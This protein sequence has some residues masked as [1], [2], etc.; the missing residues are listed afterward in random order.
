MSP[1]EEWI[2]QPASTVRCENDLKKVN[3]LFQD[4]G[5]SDGLPIIPPTP[6]RVR[7]MLAY[8]DRPW[9]SSIGKVA[10]R[11]GEATPIRLAVNAVMAGCEPEYLPVLMAAVEA[12]CDPAFNLYALQATTH[13]CAPLLIV[14]GPIARELEINAGVNAFGQGRQA[15]ATIGRAVRLMLMNIGGGYP[16]TGDMATLGAPS[17]FSF[18]VAENEA[19]SPWPSLSVE[20]GFDEGISTVT[21]VGA[22]PPHN[23]ND[24]ASSS[25]IGILKMIAGT[26]RTTG[27]N[28]IYNYQEGTY[29]QPLVVF[30]PE[31]AKSVSDDGYGKEAIRQY[32]FEHAR[33]PLGEFSR[34]NIDNRF[35]RRYGADAPADLQIP[36]FKR[37]QDLLIA[38]VGGPGKHSAVFPTFGATQAITRAISREDGRPALS[39]ADL[40]AR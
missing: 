36:V 4:R 29:P 1:L 27:N 32:L 18:C 21:V 20:R 35:S 12:M 30:G 15:N 40:K 16:G 3:R 14:N 2:R 17:K 31:H 5:W 22:E 39:I 10:P 25:G 24:H 6:E 38:V 9:D 23:V 8:C 19:E 33:V 34:E 37:P 11:Y 13:P 28:D 7:D 26:M